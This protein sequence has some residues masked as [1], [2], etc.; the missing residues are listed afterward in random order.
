MI[1]NSPN[2]KHYRRRIMAILAI[3]GRNYNMRAR[4]L[5]FDEHFAWRGNSYPQMVLCVFLAIL[6]SPRN[7]HF[8]PP[9]C[10]SLI[11]MKFPY[12]DA[13]NNQ[14]KDRAR[15]GVISPASVVIKAWRERLTSVPQQDKISTWSSRTFSPRS[16]NLFVS[17]F[18]VAT[19]GQPI[20]P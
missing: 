15:L 7:L 17:E 11:S 10:G 1:I 4:A 3:L 13:V 9:A 20:K 6:K 5:V 2:F 14:V 16:L 8:P 19:Q 18:D 12:S